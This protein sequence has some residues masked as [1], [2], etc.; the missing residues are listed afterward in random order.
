V[1]S[2]GIRQGGTRTC[3]G[4]AFANHLGYPR[5]SQIRREAE[6]MHTKAGWQE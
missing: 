3:C 4:W 2:G 6:T 5:L 1:D